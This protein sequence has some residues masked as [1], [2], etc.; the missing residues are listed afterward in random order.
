M[1]EPITLIELVNKRLDSEFNKSAGRV[2]QQIARISKNA[3]TG[4]QRALRALDT[5][6][7]TL[8]TEGKKFAK[9][10]P[11]LQ[12]V[13]LEY[14]S[15]L[16]AT[17]ALVSANSS[18]VQDTSY[19]IAPMAVTAKVFT[20]VSAELY[21]QGIDPLTALTSFQSLL[22]SKG[23]PW[24]I[25]DLTFFTDQTAISFI[26]TEA[27]IARME[28][29]G[30]GYADLTRKTILDG[31]LNGWNPREIAR[32]LRLHAENIPYSSAE[33]L[34]R[35]LQL[36]SYREASL[37][38]EAING[39]FIVKKIRIAT[40]DQRTCLSCIALHG[41]ELAPGQRVDDHY[42]GRCT[43]FYVVPGGREFPEFMQTDSP[44]GGR[45]MVPF[46]R[47]PE[48][49]NSLPAERQRQQASFTRSPGKY[50]AFLAGTPL[51]D[52]ITT[53]TDDVFGNQ[54]V[55]NSLV[56]MFGN[57]AEQYYVRNNP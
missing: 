25:P 13:L 12:K 47:G 52:F 37:A 3:G 4:I 24:R 17:Q 42:R 38:M 6:A 19:G 34:M 22:K 18:A 14:E 54:V 36:T 15:L 31:V 53:H 5:A 49:F 26:D 20:K 7:N 27:W 56:G 2:L 45:R 44:A 28:K 10:D 48:W 32:V 1:A 46:Q 23:I 57:D 30:K 35:T 8:A 43:E 16:L 11:T 40:L 50:N 33:N 51:S 9:D 39:R 55:E 29:W 21:V 41:S